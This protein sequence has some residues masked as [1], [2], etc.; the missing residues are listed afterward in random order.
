MRCPFFDNSLTTNYIIFTS[1]CVRKRVFCLLLCKDCPLENIVVSGVFAIA[2]TRHSLFS[3]FSHSLYPPPAAVVLKAPTGT[4]AL[5]NSNL[6]FVINK[7]RD[8]ELNVLGKVSAIF[9]PSHC[10]NCTRAIVRGSSSWTFY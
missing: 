2:H 7:R 6:D 5:T 8:F 3:P 9:F 10:T 1:F 4:V